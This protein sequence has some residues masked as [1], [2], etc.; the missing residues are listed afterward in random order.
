MVMVLVVGMLL[1]ASVVSAQ[2]GPIFGKGEIQLT[3]GLTQ[4]TAHTVDTLA[5]AAVAPRL[6]VIMAFGIWC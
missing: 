2:T 6:S 4:F 3:V 5:L 1:V